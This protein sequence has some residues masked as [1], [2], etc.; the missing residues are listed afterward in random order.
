MGLS[1]RRPLGYPPGV[2]SPPAL[3]PI[4]LLPGLDG[5]GELFAPLLA[6]L[7]EGSARVVAYPFDHPASWG[8]LGEVVAGQVDTSRPFLVFAESFSGPVAMRF[9]REHGERCVGFVACATFLS[10]PAPARVGLATLPGLLALLPRRPPGWVLRR[11]LLSRDASPALTAAV[12]D[13]I[14]RVP[15][16]TIRRR[17]QMIQGLRPEPARFEFE[18]VYVRALG[19]CLVGARSGAEFLNHV[20]GA[21]SRT[22]AGPHLLAQEEPAAVAELLIDL[23]R[24]AA[25]G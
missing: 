6:E 24:R 22:V 17:L 19:D 15:P 13:T 21:V 5:T 18:V 16:A 12:A 23:R 3:P 10:S 25:G 2:S 11:L 20:P 14:E 9:L 7:P 8:A 1:T 4:Y